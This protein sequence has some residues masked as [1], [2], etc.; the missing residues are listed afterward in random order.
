M[1]NN[2]KISARR[3]YLG[4]E[5]MRRCARQRTNAKTKEDVKDIPLAT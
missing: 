4:L 1:H 5:I 2:R 3:N